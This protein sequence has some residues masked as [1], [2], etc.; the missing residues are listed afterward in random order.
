MHA[1]HFVIFYILEIKP[2]DD[3]NFSTVRHYLPF[4]GPKL[5]DTRLVVV[6][7]I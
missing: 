4:L 3:S 5:N 1:T 7:Y 2:Y 6:Y